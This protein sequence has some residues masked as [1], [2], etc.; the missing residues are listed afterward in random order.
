[1]KLNVQ[2]AGCNKTC[3]VKFYMASWDLEYLVL[4]WETISEDNI[5]DQLS[6]LRKT[7]KELGIPLVVNKDKDNMVINYIDGRKVAI[8]ECYG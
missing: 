4:G 5:L 8:D 3:E 1:M 2:V 6:E 7:Q